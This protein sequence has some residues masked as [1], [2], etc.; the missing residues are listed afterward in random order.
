MREALGYSKKKLTEVLE[1]T[2]SP[3]AVGQYERGEIRPTVPALEKLSQKL[4]VNINWLL[5]GEG[6]DDNMFLPDAPVPVPRDDPATRGDVA[7][8]RAGLQEDLQA[9][10]ADISRKLDALA[11]LP[12]HKPE[13]KI[14]DDNVVYIEDYIRSRLA[15]QRNHFV[16]RTMTE[17]DYPI[18][19]GGVIIDEYSNESDWIAGSVVES[20]PDDA[21]YVTRVQGHSMEPTISNGARIYW[22]QIPYD[23]IRNG[24]LVVHF[25]AEHMEF[26]LRRL[27]Y[28]KQK[29]ERVAVLVADN[30][31]VLDTTIMDESIQIF[32]IVVYA[33][34][35][36]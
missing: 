8:L 22:R 30:P 13:L 4:K 34:N 7:D 6:G 28:V 33:R 26:K 35:R 18:G 21:E 3:N 29:G 25:N 24:D 15:R 11:Q 20:V 31:Q 1:M 23:E 12:E 9:G 16:E 32:G 17:V 14:Q 19:A 2:N 36:R 5:T 10:L 27:H